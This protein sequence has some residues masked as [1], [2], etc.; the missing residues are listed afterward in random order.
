MCIDNYNDISLITQRI[1]GCGIGHT[2][3][4]TTIGF[5]HTSPLHVA[6]FDRLVAELT[7]DRAPAVVHVVDERL[8]DVARADGPTASAVM[9]GIGAALDDLAAAGV[10]TVVC[11]CST[12]GGVSEQI[13]ERRGQRVIR[14]DRPMVERAVATAPAGWGRVGVV[15][16]LESTID[17]TVDLLAAVAGDAGSRID[18]QTLVV[19]GAWRRFEADDIDGYLELVARALP[20]LGGRC[21]VIVLAQ[22]SMAAAADLAGPDMAMPVLSSSRLAVSS[23]LA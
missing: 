19:E 12:I 21:D 16:A 9:M 13:G 5:L 1:I 4:V 10:D 7:A 2:G 18:V 22:A 14:V 3:L 23:L 6:T 11:T 17:P 15:A 8:L 20:E